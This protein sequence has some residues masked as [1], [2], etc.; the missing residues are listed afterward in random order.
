LSCLSIHNV[1]SGCHF[2]LVGILVAYC[3]VSPAISAYRAPPNDLLDSGKVRELF[4]IDDASLLMV[5]TD[6]ISAYD[7]I[8]SNGIPDK[9]AVLCQISGSPLQATGCRVSQSL[10]MSSPLVQDP[11]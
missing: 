6:R 10:T 1:A 4:K 7:E 9:G 3:Q 8:L 2:R 11:Q 5:A